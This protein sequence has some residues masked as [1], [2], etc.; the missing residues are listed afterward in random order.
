MNATDSRQRTVPVTCS[1]S[2][3]TDLRR[4]GDRRGGD[5]GDQRH[6]RRLDRDLAERLRHDLGG[7]LHQGGMER[8]GYRQQHGAPHA[9]G[10][11]DLDRALDRRLVTGHHDLP[12]AI[13]VGGL[14]QL[15]LRGFGGDR[16]RLFE[17][18]SQQRRHRAHADRNRAL[19][20][21]AANANEPH[22]IG[23]RQR[24]GGGQGGVFADRMAGHERRVALEIDARF[25]FK[26]PHRGERYRDQRRLRILGEGQGLGRALPHH[27]GEL[28]A[29]RLV[30][31]VENPPRN[32]EGLRQRL[33]HADSLAA[34]ARKHVRRRHFDDPSRIC[35]P[36][37]PA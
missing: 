13:V 3:R 8:C 2:P 34:L 29:E 12:A 15:A 36:K 1:T 22:R 6:R 24:T 27:R 35:G 10:L 7:G 14:H 16:R 20:R 18:D 4:I 5:I 32:R 23:D 25:R 33:A 17:I 9:L 26:D 31:L 19:H 30:D 37:T 11:G 21:A 28:V